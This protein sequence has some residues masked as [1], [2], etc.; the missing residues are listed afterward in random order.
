[1]CMQGQYGNQGLGYTAGDRHGPA[2]RLGLAADVVI[3]VCL[4]LLYRWSLRAPVQLLSQ[5]LFCTLY[6]LGEPLP[7]RRAPVT[8]S[9]PHRGGD[10]RWP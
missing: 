2:I 6:M 3:G 4:I 10:W 8:A 5:I 9:L 7:Q 1:M